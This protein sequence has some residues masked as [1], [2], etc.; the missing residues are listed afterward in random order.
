M[1]W[2]SVAVRPSWSCSAAPWSKSSLDE[3]SWWRWWSSM[4]CSSSSVGRCWLGPCL[5]GPCV[6]GPCWLGPC[7]LG[8]CWLGRCAVDG[9]RSDLWLVARWSAARSWSL[10][11]RR[12]TRQADSWGWWSARRGPCCIPRSPA[13]RLSTRRL[14]GGC[15]AARPEDGDQE[16]SRRT[17]A[18]RC[19]ALRSV[20]AGL[21]SSAPR[22][23]N[24]FSTNRVLEALS[25]A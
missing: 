10:P 23:A 2:L 5:L 4:T 11:N 15:D 9:C 25:R 6:L 20:T 16:F 21:A 17:N 24:S 12:S 8:R 14:G 18:T 1:K 3:A 13:S 19:P 22:W 7:W